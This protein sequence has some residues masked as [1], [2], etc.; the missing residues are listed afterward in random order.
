MTKKQSTAKGGTK[1]K[2]EGSEHEEAGAPRSYAEVA[3]LIANLLAHPYTPEK[4]SNA[5]YD[6]LN[7]FESDTAVQ[8]ERPDA[9]PEHIE[10]V[11]N[12]RDGLGFCAF[13][14]FKRAKRRDGYEN[15]ELSGFDG[16]GAR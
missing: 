13:G 16:E 8:D 15:F 6:A 11:L 7:E 5:I 4:L 10:R 3:L 1:G 14:R 2:A 9:Q 12:A